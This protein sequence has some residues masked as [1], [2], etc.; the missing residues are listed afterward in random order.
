M[1]CWV[2]H[3]HVFTNLVCSATCGSALDR[4]VNV[5]SLCAWLLS[6]LWCNGQKA[7]ERHV[8]QPVPACCHFPAGVAGHGHKHWG[9][10]YT[11]RAILVRLLALVMM[12]AAIGMAIYSAIHFKLRGEMLLCALGPASG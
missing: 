6:C 4:P 5:R 3:C 10:D 9:S 7:E 12:A 1:S 2:P 8:H 11:H